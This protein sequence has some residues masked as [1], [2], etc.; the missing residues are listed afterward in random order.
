[1]ACHNRRLK[2]LKCLESLERQHNEGSFTLAIYLVD[3]GSTDGTGA[4]FIVTI[5]RLKCS[6]MKSIGMVV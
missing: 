4:Q 1:M 3:D 2:T 6:L 5:P